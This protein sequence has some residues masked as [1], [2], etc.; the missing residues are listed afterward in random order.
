[1]NRPRFARTGVLSLLLVIVSAAVLLLLADPMGGLL[2]SAGLFVRADGR[3][4]GLGAGRDWP[5]MW[6]TLKQVDPLSAAHWDASRPP[7]QVE[8][9]VSPVH[10]G[11]P[12]EGNG[13][14][15]SGVPDVLAAARVNSTRCSLVGRPDVAAGCAL[16]VD[17]SG[18]SN[19]QRTDYH[20]GHL[21]VESTRL[22]TDA[23]KAR[24][25]VYVRGMTQDG[26]ALT[27]LY[28]ARPPSWVPEPVKALSG[29]GA[30]RL[31]GAGPDNESLYF[32][33]G[34]YDVARLQRLDLSTMKVQTLAGSLERVEYV[35]PSVDGRLLAL[36]N[37]P[38]RR[39]AR[40]RVL[41]VQTG[42]VSTVTGR[43]PGSPSDAPVAWSAH[44]RNR[45]Y[46]LGSGRL[47]QLQLDH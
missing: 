12:P 26:R 24:L 29:D 2:S 46:F 18:P 47:H 19:R 15:K 14:N 41:D 10:P 38:W 40:V 1:M 7:W 17:R 31:V 21:K 44:F 27:L 9:V 33:A 11:R 37:K 6:I 30:L 3:V 32:C 34:Q 45:L 4:K 23:R 28:G 43:W 16:V 5:S 25:V 36:G 13:A 22:I 39:A 42:K 35:V 8:D 20:L